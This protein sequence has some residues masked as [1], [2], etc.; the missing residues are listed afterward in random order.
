M[1]TTM[2]SLLAL[3][4]LLALAATP[5]LAAPPT[6]LTTRI[7][8]VTVYADRAQVTREARVELPGA[9]RRFTITGLPG[10]IDE[11]SVRAA[12][13]SGGGRILD[14]VV[15]RDFLA[16]ASEEAVRRAEAAVDEVN[17]ELLAITDEEAV[18]QAE[19]AQLE[20]IRAFSL[21]KLPRDMATRPV[22]ISDFRQTVD[23][24]ASTL[25]ADRQALRALSV[26]RRKLQPELAARVQKRDELLAHTQLDKRNVTVEIE[27]KGRAT[28]SVRYLTP[29]ATWQP[30]SE[31]R[32]AEGKDTISLVQLAQVIQTTGEDWNGAKLTFSTQRPADI[33]AVPEARSLLLGSG[34][35]GLGVVLG[36]MGE[37]FQRAQ[38]SYA[39]QN[40]A[41]N[42]G[43][44]AYLA[45]VDRQM[46]I[47][48][49]ST[50]T[51][52]ALKKRGTTAHFT[53]LSDRPVRTDGKPIR[54]PIA[55]ADYRL[56]TKLVAVPEVSLN[57][58]PR[59]SPST[60]PTG[61]PS[62]RSRTSRSIGSASPRAPRATPT[63]S[64]AG[65]RPSSPASGSSG[66]SS[67][68]S[69]TPR[70]C[71]PSSAT[72]ASTARRRPACSSTTSSSWS[73]C[74]SGS[75]RALTWT[76]RLVSEGMPAAAPP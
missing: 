23:Y 65:R 70:T 1:K 11:D 48:A 8:E 55:K 13:T 19:I 66:A 69:S 50:A 62:P 41:M 25:R 63:A 75:E 42:Q 54:V 29:G 43:D 24:L 47:Q 46:K 53:A 49:S 9:P 68:T 3:P 56:M 64:S 76:P 57:A 59:P 15:D 72:A 34:G 74:F 67:T 40:I 71:S 18:L 45:N 44:A 14:V 26:R 10:W 51:F 20:A 12:V 28:L 32:A 16:E 2:T 37:S 52:A 21:D 33:L 4:A 73:R 38:T 27:G 22:K 31:L 5:A 61:S 60:C 7:T 39:T 6:P 17:D 58:V 30:T 36:K 35:A